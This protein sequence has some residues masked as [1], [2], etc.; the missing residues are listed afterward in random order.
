MDWDDLRYFLALARTKTVRG[1]GATLG[2]SHATV[3]RRVE[4]LESRLGARLFE[5]TPEGFA[6]TDAG[7]RALAAATAL[8]S[9]VA[10]LERGVLGADERLAGPVR[11]T[12]W[13]GAVCSLIMPALA[14]LVHAHPGITLEV[15]ADPRPLN[16]DLR[17]A[18]IALRVLAAGASPP[19]HLLGRN[20][21]PLA[22]ASYVGRAH[23][24]AL[25]PERGGGQPRWLAYEDRAGIAAL[26]GSSS[27]PHLPLWGSF[28]D[29]D[30]MAAAARAG[31]GL[32]ILPCYFADN[33]PTLVRLTRPDLRAPG[34]VW[35]LSHPDLRATARLQAVRA[36]LR[37]AM[38]GCADRF[39]GALPAD[40]VQE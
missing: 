29:L 31:L 13:D 39:R 15:S 7:E 14:E 25:D 6:L 19:D 22:V 33:D 32:A 40:A 34:D 27:Y 23:A 26:V 36:R 20:L 3:S 37:D 35:M 5:R 4:A 28:R 18:D 12:A 2:V 21:A 11:I 16:L 9:G 17:E 1:A 10:S 30:V 8:E 38:E 24:H